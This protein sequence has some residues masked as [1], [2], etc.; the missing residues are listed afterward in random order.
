MRVSIITVCY[1]SGRTIK[2][3]IDSVN[4]QSYHNIEHVFIDGM[5]KDNTIDLIRSNSD[6]DYNLVSER[7]SGIY[8]AMNKGIGIATGEII[9]ILNSDD[10]L[11]SN[12]TV[13]SVVDVFE[14]YNV[15]IIYGHIYLAAW[16]D[17]RSYVRNWKVTNFTL[18]SFSNGWHPAHPGLVVRK[19]VYS[20]HGLYKLN[21]PIA[22]DFELML[23]FFECKG[24]SSKLYDK[25]IAVMR[26][27]GDSTN[28]NGIIKGNR[29]IK[30]AFEMNNIR[31]PLNYFFKRYYSKFVQKFGMSK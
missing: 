31:M 23:R 5:S 28:I 20:K 25:H 9:F 24:C 16:T 3:T 11:F 1:N 15:D 7:D 27:G 19:T 12:D 21:L 6:R 10:I 14:Q 18:G 29:D 2:E 4:S 30:K 26:L 17:I 13:Q 8:D 22:A